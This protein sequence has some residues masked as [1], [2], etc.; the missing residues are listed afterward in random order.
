MKK[1]IIYTLI[2]LIFGGMVSLA[3]QT[4]V[5]NKEDAQTLSSAFELIGPGMLFAGI[6]FLVIH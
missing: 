6:L 3:V 2:M 5:H 4:T 1:L